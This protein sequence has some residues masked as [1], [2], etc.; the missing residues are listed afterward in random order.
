MSDSLEYLR[1][2]HAA[3]RTVLD[4]IEKQLPAIAEA[5]D[6]I[7]AR[8]RKGGRWFYLGAGT[9]GRL[10]ILDV[11]ELRPTFGIEK[12]QVVAV[13]AGGEKAILASVEDAED[14]VESGVADLQKAGISG[15]DALLCIAASG[16][17]PYTLGAL[18]YARELGA[19]A[20]ALVCNPGTPLTESADIGIALHTGAEVLSGSTR[21]KAGSAQKMVLTM[22]STGVMNALG[23]I[24]EG[25]MVSMQPTNSKL[26]SRAVRIVSELTDVDPEEARILLEDSDWNLPIS[27]IRGHSEL[28][29][30]A[31]REK[32]EA[33]GGSVAEVLREGGGKEE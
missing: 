13:I 5:V 12:D 1:T 17:T 10:A 16:T 23:R 7:A 26:R 19:L 8:L 18:K 20:V 31:A 29:V 33:A 14:A 24:F 22:L 30:E 32:L 3:D 21:M 2:I 11:A 6:A 25:E 27:L 4:E 9:S 15:A 28:S